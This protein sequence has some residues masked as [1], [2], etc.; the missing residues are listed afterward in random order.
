MKRI[1]LFV[2]LCIP[3]GKL[4]TAQILCSANFTYTV[5]GN[6]V[7]VANTSTSTSGAFNFGGS[8]FIFGNN[9]PD[10]HFS[11]PGTLAVT[12]NTSG[13]VT[14]CLMV[15]DSVNASCADSICQTINLG[16]T[17]ASCNATISTSNTDSVFYF[18]PVSWGGIAPYSYNWVIKDTITNLVLYAGASINPMVVIPAGH[19]AVAYLIATDSVGCVAAN[20]QVVGLNWLPNTMG[21]NASFILWPDTNTLHMYYGYN[22]STGAN[23]QY[24]WNWGDGSSSTGAYPS[25]VYANAGFYTICLTVMGNGCV[26]SMCINYSIAR[27]DQSKAIHSISILNPASGISTLTS[28]KEM[29]IYPNPAQT[30]LNISCNA[31]KLTGVKIS[32]INGQ[33]VLNLFTSNT[34]IAINQLNTG[35]YFLEATTN[36]GVHTTKW[37]NQ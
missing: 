33:T 11:Y 14:I 24:T 27:M 17:P 28:N 10:A 6:T 12:Y 37:I 26:D 18:T 15:Q 22:F 5:S 8:Y 34:K 4:A 25:H 36:K 23:L 3:F 20:Y 21:C 31:E 7:T 29:Q 16:G 1:L 19:Y 32:A 35:I 30:E 13:P 9:I 2:L